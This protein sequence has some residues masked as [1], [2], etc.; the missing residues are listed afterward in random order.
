MCFGNVFGRDGNV[1]NLESGACFLRA[2]FCAV[3]N[4]LCKA[5]ALDAFLTPCSLKLLNSLQ[6]FA[7]A[8]SRQYAS[9]PDLRLF[10]ILIGSPGHDGLSWTFMGYFGSGKQDVSQ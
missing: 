7:Y 9:I 8:Y 6:I 1:N 3:R 4:A 2:W 10:S 5:L